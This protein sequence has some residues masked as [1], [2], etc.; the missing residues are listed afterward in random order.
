MRILIG[1]LF[2]VGLYAQGVPSPG[3][4]VFASSGGGTCAAPT[5][6][7]VTGSVATSF[8]LSAGCTVI[9]Y[10]TSS[11]TVLVAG[12]C[13]VGSTTYTTSVSISPPVT[14]FAVATQLAMTASSNASAS[15]IAGASV[16]THFYNGSCANN[17]TT[18]TYTSHTVVTGDTVYVS[19]GFC[20]ASTL[21][22]TTNTSTATVSDGT[23]TYT[24]QACAHNNG[25]SYKW[26]T[27]GFVAKNVTGGTYTFTVQNTSQGM[28]FAQFELIDIQ[29]AN[30]TS[31]V[32]SNVCT[33]SNSA[34]TNTAAPSITSNGNVTNTGELIIGQMSTQNAFTIGGAFSTLDAS[35]GNT[36]T[37]ADLVNPASGSTVTLSGSQTSA[38]FTATMIGF[39]P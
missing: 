22:T 18:C 15:Y 12:T 26:T 9:C 34:G 25:D 32:D 19:L 23:N 29:G 4:G 11:I 36:I 6:S 38:K 1:L 14:Y 30:A 21:C 5:F 7:P 28:Y 37:F 39:T 3:P 27:W 8:T 31:P 20:V 35:S 24:S 33:S 10:S 16:R 17:S 13:P 2:A